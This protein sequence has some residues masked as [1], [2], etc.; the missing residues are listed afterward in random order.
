MVPAGGLAQVALPAAPALEPEEVPALAPEEE[1]EPDDPPELALVEAF[2]PPQL[3]N[4]S[5]VAAGNRV[6]KIARACFKQT[7][8]WRSQ[9]RGFVYLAS[10]VNLDNKILPRAWAR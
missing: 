3:I 5:A 10:V 8:F 7:P 1:P 4:P 6:K 2:A 9:V